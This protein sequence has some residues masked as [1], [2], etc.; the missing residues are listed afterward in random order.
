MFVSVLLATLAVGVATAS[1]AP[2]GPRL[3][4]VSFGFKDL[5]PNQLVDENFDP[6]KIDLLTA[7]P[8]GG[9]RHVVTGTSRG[10]HV[11][12]IGGAS[13]SPDG[14]KLAFGGGKVTTNEASAN[15]GGDIYLVDAD[16]GSMRRLTRLGEASAPVFSAD[17][18]SIFFARAGPVYEGT[19]NPFAK[20]FGVNKIVVETTSIWQVNLDG[21]GLRQLTPV[22]TAT[23]D[24]PAS[25]SSATGQLAFS[26]SVCQG[27]QC[28]DSARL[29]SPD[30]GAE[31]LLADDASEPEF[32]PDGRLVALASDRD[33]NWPKHPYRKKRLAP[34]AELYLLDLASGSLRRLTFSRGIDEGSASWDPS[35]Q[36]I[37]YTQ[38]GYRGLKIFELNLDGSCRTRV[39][40]HVG[41]LGVVSVNPGWQP[42][43]GREAGRISC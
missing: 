6:L 9:G 7:G 29:L 16:G 19:G 11:L 42:G 4:F 15:A 22:D 21:S 10:E 34:V 32:S 31:S 18:Q 17:G 24:Y 40:R 3:G 2:T 13:W 20:K 12:P 36:R 43:P 37:A 26:R 14:S 38:V 8:L 25:V 5:K 39:L 23:F 33:Q 1:A 30:T 35:G 27:S 28:S 41:E